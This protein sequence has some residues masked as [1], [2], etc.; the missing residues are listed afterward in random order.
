MDW[1]LTIVV[2]LYLIGIFALSIYASGQVHD[3]A[4]YVVAG[5][6]LPLWLAWGTLMATWFG[7]ATVLGAAEAA[8]DEGVRGTLLDPFASGLALIV[9]GLF[10]AKPMW[11]MKLLTVGDFFAQRYGP[12]AELVASFLLIP[13]YLGWVGAQFVALGNLQEI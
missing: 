10:F 13:G 1:P 6:R 9:A 5:R 12:R 8:R 11:E 7:A 4:D 3:E 2:S